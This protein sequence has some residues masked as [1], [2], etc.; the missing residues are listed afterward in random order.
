M[1]L[2]QSLHRNVQL[3]GDGTCTVYGDRVRTW[4]ESADRIARLAAGFAQLGVGAGD[5]IAML[6][7]NSD[8]YH[9]YLYATWWLGAHGGDRD[10][11][12]RERADGALRQVV[13]EQPTEVRHRQHPL[14][15]DVLH[16]GGPGDVDVEVDR[17]VVP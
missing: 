5:R 16:A 11:A 17:V 14:R 13:G 1:Y 6:S 4:T 10:E 12:R 2:T 8:R 7:L 9:E 3:D 15:E